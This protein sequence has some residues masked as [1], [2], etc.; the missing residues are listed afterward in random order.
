MIDLQLKEKSPNHLLASNSAI[1]RSQVFAKGR[2][3]MIKNDFHFL[4]IERTNV[5]IKLLQDLCEKNKCN[6]LVI[7]PYDISSTID[8]R[9]SSRTLYLEIINDYSELIQIIKSLERQAIVLVIGF[10]TLY[11]SNMSIN[12]TKLLSE[13]CIDKLVADIVESNLSVI[14]D[15]EIHS[16]TVHQTAMLVK[17][18]GTDNILLENSAIIPVDDI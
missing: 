3:T 1:Y 2:V 12:S 9:P 10:D 17:I 4:S 13:Y 18:N 11:H 16:L 14:L 8:V 7:A 5:L 15:S 6:G